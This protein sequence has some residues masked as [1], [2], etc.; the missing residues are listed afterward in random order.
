MAIAAGLT[1]VVYYHFWP[2][3]T[4]ILLPCPTVPTALTDADAV[5][6]DESGRAGLVGA[7]L[8]GDHLGGRRRAAYFGVA[9]LVPGTC[10]RGPV[11]VGAAQGVDPAAAPQG[12]RVAATALGARLVVRAVFVHPAAHWTTGDD[13]VTRIDVF[14]DRRGQTKYWSSKREEK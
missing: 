7:T 9:D 3:A 6:A 5:A 4:G 12:A 11:V 1:P 13:N 2:T 8:G 14:A 10:A